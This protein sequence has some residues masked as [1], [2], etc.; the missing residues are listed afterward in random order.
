VIVSVNVAVKI[1]EHEHAN[2]NTNSS[3]TIE[4][5]ASLAGLVTGG[6]MADSTDERLIAA[7][8]K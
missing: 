3:E 7:K 4:Q 8:N 2:T 5:L 6:K 1:H